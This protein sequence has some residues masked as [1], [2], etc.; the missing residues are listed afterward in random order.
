[1]TGDLGLPLRFNQ[2]PRPPQMASQRFADPRA[3]ML[4]APMGAANYGNEFGRPTILGFF[5]SFAFQC[6]GPAG[7]ERRGYAK[8]FMLAGG[9]GVVPETAYGKRALPSGA[10]VVLLGGPALP[11]GLGGGAAS[12]LSAGANS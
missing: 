6:Q 2:Q 1:M 5:R 8:P 10:R 4:E 11:I 9:M 3:I 7:P 12:S